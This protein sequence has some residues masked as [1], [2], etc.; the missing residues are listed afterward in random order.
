MLSPIVS[1][2]EPVGGDPWVDRNHDHSTRGTNG[3]GAITSISAERE[4]GRDKGGVRAVAR[5]VRPP[6]KGGVL[7]RGA[8][9]G[10]ASST[11]LALASAAFFLRPV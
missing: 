2:R 5:V 8:P 6:G 9:G 4:L 1:I 11:D 7:D 3:R 10:A